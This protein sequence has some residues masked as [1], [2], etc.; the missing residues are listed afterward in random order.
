MKIF[1]EV[2]SI[3]MRSFNDGKKREMNRMKWRNMVLVSV[4]SIVVLSVLIFANHKSINGNRIYPAQNSTNLNLEEFNE[5]RPYSEPLNGKEVTI[6]EAQSKLPF[7]VVLPSLLGEPT[8]V[9]LIEENNFLYVIYSGKMP[10]P[11]MS[12]DNIIDSGAIILMEYSNSSV[13]ESD[14]RIDSAIETIKETGGFLEKVTINGH[15]G[16]YGGNVEH[17]V[18]WFT[19]TTNFEIRTNP[20]VP[21]SDL[22]K[23]AESI[24]EH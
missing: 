10:T 21:F 14:L 20:N 6:N 5:L 22:I 24:V 2:K 15:H 4:I 8:L 7:K 12:F 13:Q 23:I 19:S 9:K 16:V 17:V 18:Y 3:Y 11:D 1:K